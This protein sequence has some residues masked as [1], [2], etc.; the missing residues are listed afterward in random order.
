ME[1]R[2][3]SSGP[4]EVAY[5]TFMATRTCA[6]LARPLASSE[7]KA[8][9]RSATAAG[10]AGA[11]AAS[12][13][14]RRSSPRRY[15]ASR[16]DR[17]SP[18]HPTFRHLPRST[19]AGSQ[20]CGRPLNRVRGQ[21]PAVRIVPSGAKLGLIAGCP[22]STSA[23]L[24]CDGINRLGMRTSTSN[25]RRVDF[26][27]CGPPQPLQARPPS[28]T[29]PGSYLSGADWNEGCTQVRIRHAGPWTRVQ[30]WKSS[31]LPSR[32]LGVVELRPVERT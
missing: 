3:C 21:P 17:F 26:G 10:E 23:Q 15:P 31:P 2:R 1:T 16:L 22:R 4:R 9:S 5:R 30:D 6:L 18:I 7:W 27:D 25:V 19:P 12:A 32:G 29:T 20:G 13:R 24:P 11:R 28:R 8:F 14:R